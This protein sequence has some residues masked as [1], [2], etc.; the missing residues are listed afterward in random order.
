MKFLVILLALAVNHYWTRDRDILN[1]SWFV[2]FQGWLTERTNE[3]PERLAR[4]TLLYPAL[5]LLLPA[6]LL[7]VVLW[8]VD[9][10]AFGLVTLLVHVGVLLAL[11]DRVNVNTLTGRY[12]D[13]WRAENYEG[14][15]LLLQ[16][17]WHQVSLDNCD[18]RAMLHEEF[19]RFL[20]S[21]YFE[22]LFAVLFWYLLLGPTG[23][24][25]YHLAF[26]YRSRVWQH[27]A[28]EEGELVL[29]LAYV[30]EWVPARLLALTFSLAGDFV[31]AFA[32]LREV[33][34]D[35]DRSAISVVHTCALAALGSSERMVL[36]RD[37]AADDGTADP[38]TTVLIDAESAVDEHT[39]GVRAARQV[40]ELLALL[41]RS[42]VI[43]VSVLA[44][45]ALYGTGS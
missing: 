45:M 23:A 4:H 31:G 15:F 14:A 12:L 41:N 11:F 22:R 2:R 1:D 37:S 8:L 33:V 5:V 28:T 34:M 19:C 44:I 13:L 29:R 16:E 7:G 24:L 39:L 10:V 3:F 42:Q 38:V 21:S 18:D 25:F 6:A 17:R 43:W 26:L 27:S 36:V 20:M 32:R 35:M 30:L 9:G 40:E